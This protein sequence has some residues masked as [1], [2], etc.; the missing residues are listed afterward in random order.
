[1]V[2]VFLLLIVAVGMAA[3][4]PPKEWISHEYHFEAPMALT[5]DA[6]IRLA[7]SDCGQL[8]RVGEP[9]LPFRT[10]RLAIPSGCTVEKVEAIPVKDPVML[11]GN[12]RIEY[13]GQP[14]S[15]PGRGKGDFTDG[16]NRSIYSSDALYPSSAAELISIQR[17]AGTD[18][19]IV[20]V[21]PVRYRPAS[22][23]LNFSPQ[24]S[25]RLKLA[26]SLSNSTALARP[27]RPGLVSDR[28]AGFVD[29]PEDLA[30]ASVM[31]ADAPIITRAPFDYLLITSSNLIAAFQ[32]LV[33]RK[34][35]DGLAVKVADIETI[36]NSVPGRDA[37]EKIR[38]YI[39]QAYANSGISY[40]LLG[41]GTTVIPCRY[42]YV[43]VD[44]PP[45][46]SYVPCDLY[47]SCLDGS[48]NGNGDRH[49]GEPTDGENGGDVDLLAE[50][51][52]G[53]APVS[54]VEQVKTFVEKTVRYE[55]AGNP[56]RAT[57]L[58]MA[59][60]LGEFPTGSCQGAD[61]FNPLLPVLDHWRLDWL[62]DRPK[63]LPQ[64]SS[65]DVIDGLNRSPQIAL[66]SGYGDPDI[67]MRMHTWELTRLTNEWPFL[68]CS[69]ACNVGQF[70]HG[71]FYP[72]S[73]GET[74][75]NGGPHGAFAAILNA[76]A[77]WFDP[78][79]PWKYSGEFQAGLFAELLQ[80]GHQH[81][82][83]ANQRSKENLIGLVEQDGRMT[84][85]WCY[86][87]IS[88]L[89]DPHVPFQIPNSAQDNVTVHAMEG[90]REPALAGRTAAPNLSLS[91][92]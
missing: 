22:G 19:A 84:Y 60:Y 75:I 14:H 73:F 49:W 8:H 46:D 61:M 82:G 51:Y 62:D 69:V 25:V 72:D 85:R 91:N 30:P 2:V 13:A 4:T 48:W 32:P 50:V 34:F 44:L 55:S 31:P 39:R 15:R 29:N 68:A 11:E 38:N 53:R 70:D 81:L 54:T 58:L 10:A 80:D 28:V 18:I 78:Q 9:A 63:K 59:A 27:P 17:M 77:G 6:C 67:V 5:N 92:H 66:Y 24:V 16:I 87:G 74:L 79:Y 1:M 3:P 7:M 21:F 88:L 23:A 42:A 57:A 40:V 47:Y 76:R 86:Y 41:G 45:K 37:P 36:T 20:R 33:D 90:R 12:W 26:P 52:V 89:G 35:Q 71:K 64:W 56:N 65:A 83:M 43:S